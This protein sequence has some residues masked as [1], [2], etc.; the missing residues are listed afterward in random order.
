MEKS[1]WLK[2]KENKPAS[3]KS[4]SIPDESLSELPE[5]F[6][7]QILDN[8]ESVIVQLT[9]A[10]KMLFFITDIL[11]SIDNTDELDYKIK[12]NSKIYETGE[13]PTSKSN[14]STE[15]SIKTEMAKAFAI[16]NNEHLI[17]ESKWNIKL[18]ERGNAADELSVGYLFSIVP[19]IPEKFSPKYSF[20]IFLPWSNF[21]DKIESLT[22]NSPRIILL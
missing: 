20:I 2:G 22:S 4:L 19:G 6:L 5:D 7:T 13:L 10:E 15:K 17:R 9:N 16:E 12:Y 14:P 11:H 21:D 18:V 1:P 8:V 3:D